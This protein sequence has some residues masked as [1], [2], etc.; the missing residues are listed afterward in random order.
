MKRRATPLVTLAFIGAAAG[1]GCSPLPEVVQASAD[2]SA[3]VPSDAVAAAVRALPQAASVAVDGPTQIG[4]DW[5]GRPVLGPGPVTFADAVL[6]P[7][8]GQVYIWQRLTQADT[9]A[10]VPT[11]TVQA[12]W[13]GGADRRPLAEFERQRAAA[14]VER[15]LGAILVHGRTPTTVPAR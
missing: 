4:T 10:R 13:F 1:G 5:I 6:G 15:V 14:E 12:D 3:P 8:W 9:L 11:L 2:L 7:A